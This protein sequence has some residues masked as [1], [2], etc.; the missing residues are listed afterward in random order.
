MQA[1]RATAFSVPLTLQLGL[2]DVG[3]QRLALRDGRDVIVLQTIQNYGDKAI[4]YSGFAIY[5]G[6]A[7]Q[8]RP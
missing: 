5:P 6:A 2:S 7:R 1:D 3:M 8:E 4:D